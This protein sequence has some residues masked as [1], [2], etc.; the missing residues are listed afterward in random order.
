[1]CLH[2]RN[3]ELAA[4][5]QRR[6]LAHAAARPYLLRYVSA[7]LFGRRWAEE[8]SYV[9]TNCNILDTTFTLFNRRDLW[10]ETSLFNGNINLLIYKKKTNDILSSHYTYLVICP[11]FLPCIWGN[12]LKY[13]VEENSVLLPTDIAIITLSFG[14]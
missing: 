5:A 13:C 14:F 8:V 12:I 1:M 3:N 2:W 9:D 6:A 7:N 10:A 4:V 11:R